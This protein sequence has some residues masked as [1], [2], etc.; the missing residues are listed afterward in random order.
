MYEAHTEKA[1]QI[2]RFVARFPRRIVDC[3]SGWCQVV[4][5]QTAAPSAIEPIV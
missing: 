4:T 3:E 2:R 1:A 5:W